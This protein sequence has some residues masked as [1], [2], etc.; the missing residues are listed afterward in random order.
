MV[1]LV[2]CKNEK[3][4][5]KNE[6]TRVLTRLYVDSSIGVTLASMTS[7]NGGQDGRH[8]LSISLGLT[9]DDPVTRSVSPRKVS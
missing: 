4:P 6:D 9:S 2:T 8:D 7:Q 5:I 3:D 1:V